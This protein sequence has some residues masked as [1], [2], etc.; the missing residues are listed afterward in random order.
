MPE[1]GAVRIWFWR[2]RMDFEALYEEG[3]GL[4]VDDPHLPSPETVGLRQR[5]AGVPCR[6]PTVSGK[7]DPE[8]P[9]AFADLDR[10]RALPPI[11][12]LHAQSRVR[13]IPAVTHRFPVR[14]AADPLAG[15]A[16]SAPDRPAER[17]AERPASAKL[18]SCD[19]T[20]RR[21][22]VATR[23]FPEKGGR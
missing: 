1:R 2:A 17:P 12:Q 18:S 20:H 10:E 7:G 16:P 3:M 15:S 23:Q 4:D 8:Q 9:W 21:V 13:P 5:H 19:I 11:A 22:A 6:N 14:A